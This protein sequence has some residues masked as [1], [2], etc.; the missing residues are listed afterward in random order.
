MKPGSALCILA[1]KQRGFVRDG[2]TGGLGPVRSMGADRMPITGAAPRRTLGSIAALSRARD[3][4]PRGAR[5]I[6]ALSAGP[7]AGTLEIRPVSLLR[8]ANPY[9]RITA[10]TWHHGRT[11]I[12]P[13]V[14]P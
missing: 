12:Q 11:G 6:W 9:A 8:Q 3:G 13:V 4:T 1:E 5:T 7:P 2:A 14:P 10:G